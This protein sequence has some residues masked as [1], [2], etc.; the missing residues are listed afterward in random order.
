MYCMENLFKRFKQ[1]PY[2]YVWLLRSPSNKLPET[3]KY[4]KRKKNKKSITGK[5][6][7]S[8]IIRFYRITTVRNGRTPEFIA[9][10]MFF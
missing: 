4:F 7:D 1:K 10:T 9:H 2:L 6:N 3:I 8:K 5:L